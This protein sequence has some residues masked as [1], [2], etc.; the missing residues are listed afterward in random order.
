MAGDLEVTTPH[1]ASSGRE[2]ALTKAANAAPALANFID[3]TIMFTLSKM[4][5]EML[6]INVAGI[7]PVMNC[8]EVG[9]CTPAA[10]A[11][12]RLLYVA[13]LLVSL[14]LVKHLAEES[15]L[16]HVSEM[17]SV[18]KMAGLCAGWAMGDA[19]VALMQESAQ[20]SSWCVPS[21]LPHVDS[22]CSLLNFVYSF[23]I[24]SAAAVTLL[25]VQPLTTLVN[26]EKGGCVGWFEEWLED[27]FA[28]L[29]KAATAAVS[30]VFDF[31][32][33]QWLAVDLRSSDDPV[34]AAVGHH[35][36]LRIY[37]LYAFTATLFGALL[38]SILENLEGVA[39]RVFTNQVLLSSYIQLSDLLQLVLGFLNSHS[40][41]ALAQ[42]YFEF[43]GAEP[44]MYETLL[45]LLVAVF[46][47]LFAMVWL[48]L[49]GTTQDINTEQLT[50]RESVEKQ[51]VASS[52]YFANGW[53]WHKFVR[54][55]Q[56]QLNVAIANATASL[57]ITMTL[58]LVR[59]VAILSCVAITILALRWKDLFAE[60]FVRV[61]GVE[62]ES[63][64][65]R[66]EKERRESRVDD[67]PQRQSGRTD[68]RRSSTDRI[69]I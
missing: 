2:L 11:D 66:K 46:F 21:P 48:I 28:L 43:L 52:L 68:A 7:K 34:Y 14:G 33:G 62:L 12:V 38:C 37:L 5:S 63:T 23:A 58:V 26:W 6:A 53:I 49:T 17:K 51:F 20:D 24:L 50:D 60:W 59:G 19:L 4:W 55:L 1:R 57:S 65:D 30:I 22:D 15:P 54:A 13:A 35:V 67:P 47:T 10:G 61:I 8:N 29:A 39:K 69:L 27:I 9:S 25:V 32:I 40:Y 56:A 16:Q 36:L 41:T 44:T 64:D 18:P 31:A 45:T 42:L 3:G